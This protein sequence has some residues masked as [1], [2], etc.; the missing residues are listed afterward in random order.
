MQAEAAA[1]DVLRHAASK[2]MGGGVA[3]AGAMSVQVWV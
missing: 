2:A 1:S 3:G